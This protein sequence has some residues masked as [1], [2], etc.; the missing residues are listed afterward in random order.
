MESQLQRIVTAAQTALD[1]MRANSGDYALVNYFQGKICAYQN[2]FAILYGLS[3]KD[4][5]KTRDIAS[6]IEAMK[7]EA[8]KIIKSCP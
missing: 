4:M 1:D 5:W 3:P 8:D 7:I 2:S 6:E